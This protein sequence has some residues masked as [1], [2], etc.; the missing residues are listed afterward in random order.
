MAPAVLPGHPT[1]VTDSS[2]QTTMSFTVQGPTADVVVTDPITG[3]VT[4]LAGGSIGRSVINGTGYIEISFHATSQNT[5]DPATITGNEI[6]VRDANG[7]LLTLSGSPIRVGTTSIW[8]YAFTGTLADGTYTVTFIAGSFGDTSGNTNQAASETFTVSEATTT[9]TA[10]PTGGVENQADLNGRGWV[11]VTFP[12]VNGSAVLASSITSG[13]ALFTLTDAAGDNFVIDGSPVLIDVGTSTYP[14]FFTGDE[15]ATAASQ[16]TLTFTSGSWQDANGDPVT[17]ASFP[18]S[19]QYTITLGTWIDITLSP[20]AG[21]TVNT[22]SFTSGLVTLS[23]PGVGTAAPVTGPNAVIQ[24]GNPAANEYRVLVTGAFGTGQVNVAFAAGGWTDSPAT[25]ASPARAPRSRSSL[26][27]RTF[28]SSSPAGSSSTPPASATRCSRSP[29]TSS[30]SSTRRAACSPDLLGPDVGHRAGT[31]GATSGFFVLDTGAGFSNGPQ[32]WGVASMQTNFSKL[33]ALGL[34]IFA[35]AYL[36]INTTGTEHVET[37]SLA[38]LGPGGGPLVQ[39]YDLQPF[40]FAVALAGELKVSIPQTS[41]TLLDVNGGFSSRSAR[42]R[43]S[44]TPPARPSTA[45]PPASSSSAP[46][47]RARW[48]AWPACSRSANPRASTSRG[49]A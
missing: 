5:I 48:R 35:S 19:S 16:M 47:P 41:V 43:R 10:P 18:S 33:Q 14:F 7:N 32:L 42:T 40:T 49:S 28:S 15:S 9:L 39:T 37:I 13:T 6:Q 27:P 12:T 29:P 44:C 1:T 26:P 34:T 45:R 31:V 38:G 23:G 21:A 3:T 36:E 4:S 2:L 17:S 24:I 11:D 30:S 46:A 25:P 20:T 8:Q 22:G